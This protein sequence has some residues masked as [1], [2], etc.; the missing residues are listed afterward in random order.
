M[1]RVRPY[2]F[3]LR[4]GATDIIL[5]HLPHTRPSV[6]HRPYFPP[7]HSRL[8]GLEHSF[9]ANRLLHRAQAI[10]RK[11]CSGS[12]TRVDGMSG[13]AVLAKGSGE[14]TSFGVCARPMEAEYV[15]PYPNSHCLEW[16]AY[17]DLLYQLLA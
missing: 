7:S 1:S 5:Q 4:Y 16:Y 10:R 2:L 3:P 14:Y 6:K 9:H 8:H 15:S 11:P 13:G 17:H 12:D